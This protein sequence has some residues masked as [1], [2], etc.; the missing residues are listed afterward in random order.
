MSCA[1][2]LVAVA[3][4]TPTGSE[5]PTSAEATTAG[6]AA[7]D[8]PTD[9][10]PTEDTDDAGSDDAG[11]PTESGTG[12]SER[13]ES[14][15]VTVVLDGSST[16]VEPTDVYCSGAP[17]SIE[18]LIGKTNNQLPLIEVSGSHFAMVKLDQR[19]APERT[20]NPQGITVGEDW[21]TFTDATVGGAT[22]DGSMVCTDWED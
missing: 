22:L 5:E 13:P 15:S 12:P 21:V 2:L 6:P 3:A 20:E 17:G 16:V 7:E 1:A 9:A 4:C 8:E 11:D 10:A 14:S 19:G 18:H